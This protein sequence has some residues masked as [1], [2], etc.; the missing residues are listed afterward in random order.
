MENGV[1]AHHHNPLD[2]SSHTTNH[3]MRMLYNATQVDECVEGRTMQHNRGQ[4]TVP[5]ALE[6]QMKSAHKWESTK[7]QNS[8]TATANNKHH[9]HTT[10]HIPPRTSTH[11]N[12]ITTC[13]ITASLRTSC[14]FASQRR[15]GAL[16]HKS[17]ECATGL[18]C[19][20]FV[21]CT[22]VCLQVE[23]CARLDSSIV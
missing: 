3:E 9:N 18:W 17:S 7:Q 20:W 8:N 6:S 4:M 15:V 1:S 22:E 19:Y 21:E 23:G 14:P 11:D 10:L 5:A 2:T 16:S 13:S 12:P